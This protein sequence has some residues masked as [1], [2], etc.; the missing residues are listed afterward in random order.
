MYNELQSF[1]IALFK[2]KK[3][4]LQNTALV[5]RPR[6][7]MPGHVGRDGIEPPT[8]GFSVHTPRLTE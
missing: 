1:F 6:L 4:R 3:P 5:V 8:H 7:A 2:T